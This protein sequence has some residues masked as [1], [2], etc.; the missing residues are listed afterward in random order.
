MAGLPKIGGRPVGMAI[1][2]WVLGDL[3][4]LDPT[5]RVWVQICTCGSD[6]NPTQ[7]NRAWARVLFSTRE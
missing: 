1:R 6:P 5:G 4:V 7:T 3:R 2:V